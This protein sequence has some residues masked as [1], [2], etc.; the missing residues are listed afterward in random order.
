MTLERTLIASALN[1]ISVILS[2]AFSFI[3]LAVIGLGMVGT[4]WAR[5]LA[6]IISLVLF[7]YILNRYVKL[8]FDKEALWKSS[9]ASALMVAAIFATDL[10]RGFL[11]PESY[12]FLVFRLQLL[13]LYVVIGAVAYFLALVVLKSIKKSDIELFQEYLPKRFRNLA[14][15]LERITRVE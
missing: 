1:V 3:A 9:V 4:A 11:L 2:I 6:S 15:L 5:T 14:S 13:P 8:S 7:L 10:I 12:E